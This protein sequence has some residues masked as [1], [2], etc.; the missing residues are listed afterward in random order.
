[1]HPAFQDTIR[2]YDKQSARWPDPGTGA[3]GEPVAQ[4][5]DDGRELW[6]VLQSFLP[7]QREKDLA[8]LLYHCNLKAREIMKRCPGKFNDVNEIYRLR[9]NIVDRLERNMDQIRWRL[10]DG[11]SEPGDQDDQENK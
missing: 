10:G 6:E 11:E 1:M 2:F 4:E 3:P 7:T 9:R 5:E 8:Y